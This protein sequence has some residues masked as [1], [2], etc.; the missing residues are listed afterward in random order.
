M[1]R[2]CLSLAASLCLIGPPSLVAQESY[3][4]RGTLVTP[5][6]LVEH[7]I[8]LVRQG[9]IA[10]VGGEVKLAPQDTVID[11]HGVIAPGLIDLHNHLTYNIFPRW[12]PV[13]EF[14]NRY[15][16]QKK[17]IYQTLIESPHHALVADGLECEM[18]RYAEVKAITEG[19]TSLVGSMTGRLQCG[20]CAQPRYRTRLACGL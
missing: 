8:V 7:G 15:D 5:A 9:K 16:W 18:E 19:E 12:H 17:Q 11:T 1:P 14:G 2:L 20:T 4:L 10:A 6:G 3:A 13:E